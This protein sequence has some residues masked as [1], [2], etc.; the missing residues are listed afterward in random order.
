V[1]REV[2]LS[3]AEREVRRAMLLGGQVDKTDNDVHVPIFETRRVGQLAGL[4]IF[5][6]LRDPRSLAE[7][8]EKLIRTLLIESEDPLASQ[9]LIKSMQKSMR[10]FGLYSRD[11]ETSIEAAGSFFS[12]A[13][14][15]VLMQAPLVRSQGV[16]RI[17]IDGDEIRFIRR[18]HWTKAA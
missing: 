12:R 15:D 1:E 7:R 14:L 6:P 2:K 13:N 8:L 4:D 18:P 17:E 11:V 9:A 16:L 5:R 3:E 10:D